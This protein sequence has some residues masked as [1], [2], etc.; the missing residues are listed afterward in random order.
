MV[1]EIWACNRAVPNPLKNEKKNIV[2]FST[3][4]VP[5][6]QVNFYR[7]LN[8]P[9]SKLRFAGKMG[10]RI[11]FFSSN[12]GHPTGDQVGNFWL[13]WQM[14]LLVEMHPEIWKTGGTQSF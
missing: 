12:L 3:N 6:F 1:I 13:K 8:G 2:I 10:K 7:K 11:F 4:I 9:I 5:A 14:N